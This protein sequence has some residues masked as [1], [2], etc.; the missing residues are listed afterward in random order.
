MSSEFSGPPARPR[1]IIGG[2]GLPG[3]QSPWFI[4]TGGDAN[5]TGGWD[6]GWSTKCCVQQMVGIGPALQGDCFWYKDEET[7]LA[8]G[9]HGADLKRCLPCDPSD[10]GYTKMFN[11]CP[12]WDCHGA[13]ACAPDQPPGPQPP[14]P[15]PPGPPPGSPPGP[16]PPPPRVWTVPKQLLAGELIVRN[17]KKLPPTL[18]V[19]SRTALGITGDLK[20]YITLLK[21]GDLLIAAG[22]C[23]CNK[24][25]TSEAAQDCHELCA[26]AT[27]S[28]C[29]NST[30]KP[31]AMWRSTNSGGS[32]GERILS[33][34]YGI[35]PGEENALNTLRDGTVLMLSDPL[36]YRSTDNAHSWVPTVQA[37]PGRGFPNGASDLCPGTTAMQSNHY[38]DSD[39]M[40]W[41]VVEV[42]TEEGRKP[43]AQMPSGA[44][45]FSDDLIHRS[46]DAGRHWSLF[47]NGTVNGNRSQ[48]GLMRGTGF[49]AQSGLYRRT[50]GTL[51][52]GTRINTN[53]SYDSCA[54]SQLWTSKNGGSSFDCV[55]RPVAG[56]CSGPN[57]T[58][59]TCG[60]YTTFYRS[61]CDTPDYPKFLGP[62]N[63]YTRFTKL[64]DGRLLL[65][66]SHRLCEWLNDDGYGTGLRGVLSY[67]DGYTFDLESD[68]MVLQTQ[69]DFY[70]M[71]TK[72]R[73]KCNF[74]PTESAWPSPP[75]GPQAEQCMNSTWEWESGL[76]CTLTPVP[77]ATNLCRV[78]TVQL[79]S[80]VV[81]HCSPEDCRAACCAN[82]R[83]ESWFINIGG[84][85]GVP[86][87]DSVHPCCWLL[88]GNVSRVGKD[89]TKI[90]GVASGISVRKSSGGTAGKKPN[91]PPPPRKELPPP[92]WDP[93]LPVLCGSTT[94]FGNTIELPDGTLV[95]P[96]SF[97]NASFSTHLWDAFGPAQDGV[98]DCCGASQVAVMHWELPPAAT[99]KKTDDMATFAWPLDFKSHAD[100]VAARKSDD[101]SVPGDLSCKYTRHLGV[102]FHGGL[103]SLW[104]KNDIECQDKEGLASCQS[105]CDNDEHCAG[106]ALYLHGL[107]AG[108]CC[109]KQNNGEPKQWSAGES[110]TKQ[111]SSATCP[112]VPCCPGLACC[113]ARPDPVVPPAPP[114]APVEVSVIFRGNESYSYNKG[115][116]LVALP[117]G[118]LAAA[119]QAG[120]GEGTPD[121]RILYTVSKDG[122]SWP[123]EWSAAFSESAGQS[124]AQWQ[125]I[126]FLDSK[127]SKLWLFWSEGP[128][129]SSPNLLY[130]STTDSV[131]DFAQ[132]SPRRL[133]LNA[134]QYEN[135]KLLWPINRVVIS[136]I[137]GAWLLP[138]DWGCGTTAPTGTFTVR[139]MDN[140]MTC[141]H[142]ISN[143]VQTFD[144]HGVLV[145]QRYVCA[146]GRPTIQ[147]QAYHARIF[148]PNQQL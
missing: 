25:G 99:V 148:A 14:P 105:R 52:H 15:A 75:I 138:C 1:C 119:T 13:V 81:P 22:V 68:A 80:Q 93:Y 46:T 129:N 36:V 95:T 44:F 118:R 146:G 83:C 101:T 109:T 124:F 27:T 64:K 50:D 41:Q 34:T 86:G 112:F 121:M 131:S 39:C 87:C 49:F 6:G 74:Q 110:F 140:G 55:T 123:T 58:N 59:E 120:K 5:H 54:G 111:A 89:G 147:S 114:S 20:P 113:P 67:D 100:D 79:P 115:A 61:L 28:G 98:G 139:S 19:L 116:M 57:T 7:C 122:K 40:G 73:P 12:R 32:W 29:A 17:P 130:T 107:K 132:W 145:N 104:N 63:M 143:T 31:V 42:E 133:I 72:W 11:G 56:Y 8:E 69:D 3:P 23:G 60:T 97:N 127:T 92:K 38:G 78:G 102:S 108:R 106:F 90:N 117:G 91:P 2:N 10:K 70:P 4:Q 26:N 134:S 47:V 141:V 37:L 62:G 144:G 82:P 137:D 126:L 51:L 33:S 21:N 142:S 96:Y 136:P 43:G 71:I 85:A 24:G 45:V 18:K 77:N 84:N 135:R 9:L 16:P 88:D 65:T 30:N 66:Y 94:G 53:N 125:P 103:G 48:D 35:Y 128:T 76:R